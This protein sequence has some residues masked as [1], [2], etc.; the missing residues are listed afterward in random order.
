MHQLRVKFNEE[1]EGMIESFKTRL[2]SLK[3]E[4]MREVEK[5]RQECEMEK[6]SALL[7]VRRHTE[8]ALTISSMQ[9]GPNRRWTNLQNY[10]SA[11]C[12]TN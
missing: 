4:M 7:E 2:A 10:N 3:D 1:K 8:K 11:T 12:M 5:V 6:A 9:V